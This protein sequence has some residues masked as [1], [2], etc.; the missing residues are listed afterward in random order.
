MLVKENPERKKKISAEWNKR[1][2]ARTED[3]GTVERS[4]NKQK[5]LKKQLY[6]RVAENI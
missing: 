2:L 3:Y 6:V 1:K 4:P 5:V